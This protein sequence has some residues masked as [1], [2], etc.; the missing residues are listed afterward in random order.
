M[1]PLR[2]SGRDCRKPV[3]RDGNK[4]PYDSKTVSRSTPLSEEPFFAPFVISVDGFL[5]FG[6][7]MQPRVPD[8]SESFRRS[9][10]L[11]HANE[12]SRAI[13]R[14]GSRGNLG[15]KKRYPAREKTPTY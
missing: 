3:A 2:H 15:K 11:L 5:F 4:I 6:R 12:T 14:A 7:Y 1:I 10:R 13:L 8:A 9:P